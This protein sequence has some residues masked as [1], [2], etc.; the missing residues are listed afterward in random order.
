MV[1]RE[2]LHSI[3]GTQHNLTILLEGTGRDE[4]GLNGNLHFGIAAN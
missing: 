4:Y 3:S 2:T 1:L